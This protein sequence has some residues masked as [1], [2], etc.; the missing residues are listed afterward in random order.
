MKEQAIGD[1]DRDDE[2]CWLFFCM[3]LKDI[4]VK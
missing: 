2:A 3:N 4:Y 1:D